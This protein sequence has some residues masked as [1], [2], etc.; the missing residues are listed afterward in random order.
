MKNFVSFLF[1]KYLVPQTQQQCGLTIEHAQ[2]TDE[3]IDTIIK[4]YC[5]ESGVRN[6]LKQIEKV[7][8]I[9]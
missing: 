7:I 2:I 6:L 1:Q 4:N 8:L 5:R 3:A 9:R